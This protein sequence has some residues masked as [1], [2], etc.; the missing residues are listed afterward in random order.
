MVKDFRYAYRTLRHNPGFALTAIGSIALA[1]G[2][3]SAIFSFQHALLLRPL[4]I[5]KRSEVVTVS[6]RTPAGSFSG[7]SYPDFTELRDKN[8]SFSGLTTYRLIPA[9]YARDDKTQPQFKVGLVTS[10]NFFDVLG[11]RPYLG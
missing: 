11:I 6:G 8:R 9:G 10:G 2:A 3:N 4:A 7:F 1:I 5:E